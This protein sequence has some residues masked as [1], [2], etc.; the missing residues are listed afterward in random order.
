MDNEMIA[1]TEAFLRQTF[2]DSA[3]F[4]NNP[5]DRDYRLEHS[6]RVANIAKSIA[7]AVCS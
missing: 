7:D 1:G 3:Y 2:A 6:Y 5:K 4:R